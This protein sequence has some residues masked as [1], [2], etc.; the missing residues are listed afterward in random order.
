MPFASSSLVVVQTAL[1]LRAADGEGTGE[2]EN[3][4]FHVLIERVAPTG[5]QRN[6]VPV[7]VRPVVE[8]VEV[9]EE[10]RVCGGV[11]AD[12]A[13]EHDVR[14]HEFEGREPEGTRLR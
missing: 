3:L 10:H 4:C 13:I 9:Q 1:E 2:H 5:V 14:T 12:A 7:A 6:H 8:V 11:T